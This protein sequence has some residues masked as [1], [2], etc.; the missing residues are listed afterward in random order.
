M[1]PLS[2]K[3]RNWGTQDFHNA[4]AVV[5]AADPVEIHSDADADPEPGLD[6]DPDPEPGPVPGS[7]NMC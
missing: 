1:R 4:A 3:G 6:P 5:A 2:E 7:Y